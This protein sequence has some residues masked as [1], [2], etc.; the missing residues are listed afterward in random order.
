MY[1]ICWR[2]KFTGATVAGNLYFKR[3]GKKI[4][5]SDDFNRQ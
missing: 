3:D 2:S 1:K 4:G 5:L